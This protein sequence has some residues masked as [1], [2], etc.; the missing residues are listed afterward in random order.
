VADAGDD[1]EVRDDDDHDLLTFL[2]T[3]IRLRKELE[4]AQ[5]DLQAGASPAAQ[6]RVDAL[7]DA[8]ARCEQ[9]SVDLPGE[10]GFLSYRPPAR[11]ASRQPAQ[12]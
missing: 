11:A 4:Q 2:E 1:A 12:D 10:Q 6:A 3:G 7:T 5:R 8:L 9:T